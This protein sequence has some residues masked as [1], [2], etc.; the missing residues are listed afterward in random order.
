MSGKLDVKS[1]LT[2][3]QEKTIERMLNDIREET[4]K[5]VSLERFIN[6]SVRLLITNLNEYGISWYAGFNLGTED[7]YTEE[8]MLEDT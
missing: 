4:G 5:D 1:C 7:Q 6:D 3:N 2:G 8:L